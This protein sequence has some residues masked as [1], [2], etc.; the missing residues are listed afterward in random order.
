MVAQRAYMCKMSEMAL[1][2]SNLYNDVT[3]KTNLNK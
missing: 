3:G 2:L 1:L